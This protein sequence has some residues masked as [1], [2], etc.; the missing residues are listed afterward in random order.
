MLMTRNEIKALAIRPLYERLIRQAAEEGKTETVL[1]FESTSEAEKIARKLEYA[2]F[3]IG[4]IREHD[5]GKG[6]CYSFFVHW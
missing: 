2:E 4:T 3:R 6:T 1:Q 5:F